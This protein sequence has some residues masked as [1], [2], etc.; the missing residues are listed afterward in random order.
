MSPIDKRADGFAVVAVGQ[1]DEFRALGWP[2][3]RKLWKLIFSATSIAA[4]PL[5]A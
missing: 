2:R 4:E 3:L 5:S 1:R